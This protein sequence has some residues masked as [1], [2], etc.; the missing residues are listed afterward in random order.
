MARQ[1][2]TPLSIYDA[3][4]YPI[5]E[6]A[7]L[8]NV[9]RTTLGA[10]VKGRSHATNAGPRHVPGVIVPAD[11]GY[12]SFTN[13]VEAFTLA[14]MR[15]EHRLQLSQIRKAIKYVESEMGIERPLA[16]QAFKTDGVSLFVEKLG[17][18]INVSSHG[19]LAMQQILREHLARI[20][21]QRGMAVRLYPM[22]RPEQP[23]SIV[24]DPKLAYG[25]P[26]LRGTGIP[27]RMIVNRFNAGDSTHA[28]A[29]DYNVAVELIEE[30]L[31]AA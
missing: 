5:A 31:R 20:D 25:R 17:K 10:W 15:R 21:Y 9:P 7:R 26:V 19:Q 8:I 2:L 18:L 27:A 29:D 24:I 14:A 16:Q 28:L 12:L 3:P 11:P 23:K 1:N 13:L 4:S 6:A 30:A 22:R